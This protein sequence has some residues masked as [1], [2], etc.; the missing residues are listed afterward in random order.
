MVLTIFFMFFDDISPIVND[1]S[2]SLI[3]TLT[4]ELLINFVGKP[5]LITTFAIRSLIAFEPISIAAN[6]SIFIYE[7]SFLKYS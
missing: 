7:L 3:G 6:L 2:P 5:F 4:I 1:S